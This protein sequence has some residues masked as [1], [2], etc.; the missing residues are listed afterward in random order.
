MRRYMM[1]IAEELAKKTTVSDS[2]PAGGIRSGSIPDGSFPGGYQCSLHFRSSARLI[3][4]D[5]RDIV[6]ISLKIRY[7]RDIDQAV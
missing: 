2:S 3:G 4:F 7:L 1:K 6:D 5:K